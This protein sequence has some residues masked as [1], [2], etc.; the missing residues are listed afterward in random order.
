MDFEVRIPKGG[1]T[2]ALTEC[3]ITWLTDPG[4]LRTALLT[5]E[6]GS[7]AAEFG[8]WVYAGG[9]KLPGLIRRRK[10]EAELFA[11]G[12]LA[13]SGKIA[14]IITTEKEKLYV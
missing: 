12:S 6:Y 10:A 7:A 13:L 4:E 14:F 5:G 3:S 1:R 11:L 8:K 9:R 2:D